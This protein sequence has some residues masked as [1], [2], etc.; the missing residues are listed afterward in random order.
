V[1][2]CVC[3]YVCVFVCMCMCVCVYVYVDVCADIGM[4]VCS[5]RYRYI[6]M[7]LLVYMLTAASA[8]VAREYA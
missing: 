2:V 6:G 7:G 3:V 4:Y 5:S 8:V 1:Y